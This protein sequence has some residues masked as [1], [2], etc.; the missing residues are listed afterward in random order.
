MHDSQHVALPSVALRHEYHQSARRHELL[1]DSPYS[2]GGVTTPYGV[3][4]TAVSVVFGLSRLCNNWRKLN[5][6]DL[7]VLLA[8]FVNIAYTIVNIV[9]ARYFRHFWDFPDCWADAQFQEV[10]ET[11]E[12]ATNFS[13][14]F[15]KTATLM[16][17]YRL[18]AI[19]PPVNIA[20]SIGLVITFLL[21][22]SSL[23]FLTWYTV[24]HVG[25]TWAQV[26]VE[27]RAQVIPALYWGVGED[28][29]NSLLDIYIFVL[30]IFIISKLNL[31]KKKRLQLMAVFFVGLIA[32]FASIASLVFRIFYV[33]QVSL[34][35][36]LY[37]AILI[38][39]NLTEMDAAVI[40]CSA[41]A[42]TSF[43]R[44]QVL[45]SKP[46]Q[47]ILR[48][49]RI[50]YDNTGSHNLERRDPNQPR[51]G[52]TRPSSQSNNPYSIQ[53]HQFHQLSETSIHG[54]NAGAKRENSLA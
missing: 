5:W 9:F 12:S 44:N 22:A 40:V 7:F 3:T 23:A 6:T 52:Q 28:A 2:F 38:N 54:D 26:A 24:P 15:S 32:I 1:R 30:P 19:S 36:T 42:C 25:Q 8:M 51:T 16:M 4:I 11:W 47:A 29:V 37:T 50:S 35:D 14:F 21:Y 33:S 49:L 48:T 10:S 18:F 45:P 17:F 27:Q 20:I 46:I 43:F 41:P 53:L 31:L 39:L 34:D 13:L